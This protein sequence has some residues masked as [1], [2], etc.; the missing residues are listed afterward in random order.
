MRRTTI[1]LAA[2]ALLVVG[3]AGPGDVV[4]QVRTQGFFIE[5]GS[6]AQ[7]A[8]VSDAVAEARFAGGELY[9]VVLAEE[10]PGGATVFSDAVQSDIGSGTVLTVAPDTVGY[11]SDEATWTGDQL[12]H[13]TEAALDAPSDTA[14][15][16]SFVATL[17][18]RPVGGQQP[19]PSGSSILPILLVVVLVVGV[20]IGLLAWR[21]ATRRKAAAQ[22][23]LD[24]VRT[25][26][27]SKLDDIANDIIDMEDEVKVAENPEATSYYEQASQTYSDAL[28]TAASASTPGQLLDL[29]AKLDVAI[30]QLDCA[31]ALLDHK[32]L[33]PKPEPPAVAQQPP[34]IPAAA[35]RAPAPGAGGEYDR[36][37]SRRS[38]PTGP[39]I[40]NTLLT[41][42]AV[43]T[44]RR[45]MFGGL[46]GGFS[47]GGF[48]R[49]VR[50]GGGRRGGMGGG[51]TVR[52]GGRRR[53]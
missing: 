51:R 12:D 38:S 14:V 20:A 11:T 32:P 37:T 31:E 43:G 42:L 5:E 25:L 13:A 19:A 21:S 28:G 40:T 52:G 30:W 1:A 39:D 17:T 16:E 50:T 18:G 10:P 36:R 15:V 44:L 4:D 7:P 33:P 41:M 9:I 6:D 3:A 23:R 35:G 45:R 47:G 22:R 49:S 53:R 8:A 26:T 27:Q 2:C 34:A 46:P 24:E 29:S 48:G